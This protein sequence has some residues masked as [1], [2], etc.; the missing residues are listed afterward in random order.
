MKNDSNIIG[1]HRNVAFDLFNIHHGRVLDASKRVFRYS[2]RRATVCNAFHNHLV[3]G[4]CQS[5]MTKRVNDIS[6]PSIE[7]RADALVA[8]GRGDPYREWAQ[9]FPCLNELQV[10]DVESNRIIEDTIRIGSW[11]L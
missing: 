6:I 3:R 8:V 7:L 10:I 1:C 5:Y 9:L 2:K 4:V 11:N